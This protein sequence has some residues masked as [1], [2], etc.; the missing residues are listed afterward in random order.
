MLPQYLFKWF[1]MGMV[2][3]QLVLVGRVDPDNK[4]TNELGV[5]SERAREWTRPYPPMLT[6]RNGV[7]V[8]THAGTPWLVVVGGYSEE[9]T[10]SCSKVEILDTSD[11]TKQW[12]CAKY[13]LP[14]LETGATY[15]L[16]GL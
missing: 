3:G 13:R 1:T 10:G 6:R 5:W 4:R 7:A 16:G 14:S 11:S 15:V 9:C 2:S 8:M 12:Y